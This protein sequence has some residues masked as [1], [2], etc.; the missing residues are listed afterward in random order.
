MM[1]ISIY[2]ILCIQNEFVFIDNVYKTKG[3]FINRQRL[4]E[5]LHSSLSTSKKDLSSM[6]LEISEAK[7]ATDA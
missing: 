5:N 6:H 7:R 4:K 2:V 3:E 1:Q